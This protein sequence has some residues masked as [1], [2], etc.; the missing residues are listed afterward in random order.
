MY[1]KS[2]W[3]IFFGLDFEGPS[4]KNGLKSPFQPLVKDL[5]WWL[6]KSLWIRFFFAKWNSFLLI[7]WDWRIVWLQFFFE[8]KDMLLEKVFNI[9]HIALGHVKNFLRAVE[10]FFTSKMGF[11]EAYSHSSKN[12]FW[13]WISQ[14]SKRFYI[15]CHIICLTCRTFLLFSIA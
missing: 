13:K 3:K 9:L 15:P 14:K 5:Q 12:R 2:L 10:N 11:L 1:Q 7:F 4:S 8:S 6:G